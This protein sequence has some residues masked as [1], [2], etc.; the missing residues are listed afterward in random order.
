MIDRSELLMN[1]ACC[2]LHMSKSSSASLS[3]SG[4]TR[5]PARV[6]SCEHTRTWDE[7]C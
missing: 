1:T 2:V 4:G 6:A 3:R 7:H 5:S